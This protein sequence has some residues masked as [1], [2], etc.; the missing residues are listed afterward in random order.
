MATD[1][2]EEKKRARE[3][4]KK[5]EERGHAPYGSDEYVGTVAQA[6]GSVDS[7]KIT[8]RI[9]PQRQSEA[10]ARQTSDGV[11]LAPQ[12]KIRREIVQ[13]DPNLEPIVK[14]SHEARLDELA[15]LLVDCYNQ[16]GS[17]PDSVLR[18]IQGLYWQHGQTEFTVESL[19][20]VAGHYL[21]TAERQRDI[22]QGRAVTRSA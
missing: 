1:L 15:K 22:Q 13:I 10:V 17:L 18:E 19:R 20:Q 4:L 21:R 11:R 9:V 7:D 14:R 5:L 16:Y 2:Q 3:M 8:S 6:E 12:L